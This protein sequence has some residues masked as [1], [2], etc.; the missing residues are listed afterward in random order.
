MANEKFATFGFSL[1][2]EKGDTTGQEFTGN[3]EAKERL[4]MRD[5]LQKDSIRRSLLG[6]KPEAASPQAQVYAEALSHCS[7]SVTE[8]PLFW[9]EAQGGLDL[10]DDNIVFKVYE[11][12]VKGQNAAAERITKKG[13]EAKQELRKKVKKDEK[14]TE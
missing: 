13:E 10:Y 9:K 12:V 4:S 14:P 2:N 7:V 11:E 5:H 3:F 6:D 8:A 1:V